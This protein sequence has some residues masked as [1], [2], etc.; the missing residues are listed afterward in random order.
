MT[1]GSHTNFDERA[2]SAGAL[3]GAGLLASA[4]GAGLQNYRDLQARRFA[5]WNA[6]QLRT[7]LDLSEMLR[8]RE[9]Q[10]LRAKDAV[11]TAQRLTIARLERQQAIA[12]A[13]SLPRS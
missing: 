7:A 10:Q 13:R 3:S 9:H 4:L 2:F 11:I 12:R 1:G 6:S 8:A 5:A